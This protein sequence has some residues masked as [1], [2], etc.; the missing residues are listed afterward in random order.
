MKVKEISFILENCDVVT[1]DGK[2]I[3]DINLSDF[4]TSIRRI[5][6]N[7]IDKMESCYDFSVELHKDANKQHYPFG[8][9][10]YEKTTFDRLKQGDITSV[11]LVLIDGYA[12]D[13]E[14]P[15]EETYNYYVKWV[16]DSDYIN[17]AQKV[18]LSKCGNLY[19]IINEQND[20]KD[21]FD[22]D[23]IND[24]EEMDFKFK[25]YDVG[26]KYGSKSA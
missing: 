3:G 9:S 4:R 10:E 6:C 7:S 14:I 11:E 17:D 26:D 19:I 15:R 16:G 5:A 25:M 21:Y 23:D 20:I 2:Y 24:E 18:Y 12:E 22:L 13:G 8:Y 1:I